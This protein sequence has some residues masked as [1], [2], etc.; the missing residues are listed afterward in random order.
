MIVCRAVCGWFCLKSPFNKFLFTPQLLC[1]WRLR[2]VT[3]VL[4]SDHIWFSDG[5][6]WLVNPVP[7]PG[8][9]V[10]WK[11]CHAFWVLLLQ[12][13]CPTKEFWSWRTQGKNR[14][15]LSLVLSTC[16]GND[17]W[18][19]F[20]GGLENQGMGQLWRNHSKCEACSVQMRKRPSPFPSPR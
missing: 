5:D 1:P 18:W 12:N 8:C 7:F 6:T 19:R 13:C 10:P 2:S 20:Q 14:S 17:N 4:N 11:A 15:P 3:I 9:A 16:V